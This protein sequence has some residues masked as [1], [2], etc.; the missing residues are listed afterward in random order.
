MTEKIFENFKLPKEWFESGD[1]D[2]KAAEIL[3]NAEGPNRIICFH[4]Q[5]AVEKYPKGFL[6]LNTDKY[7]KVHD[8]LE[9]ITLCQEIN[10]QFINIKE[11]SVILTP[12]YIESRYIAM[13]SETYTKQDSEKAM[14]ISLSIITFIKE[15]MK[16]K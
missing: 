11:S 12:Y 5:Q 9:L 1:E 15:R 14:D 6:L 4:C 16:T 10:P 13:T 2:L 7:P 3:F 8:L